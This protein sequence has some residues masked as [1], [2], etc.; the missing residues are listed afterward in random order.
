MTLWHLVG[1]SDWELVC[2]AFENL[3]SCMCLFQSVS[4]PT[5]I[6]CQGSPPATATFSLLTVLQPYCSCSTYTQPP[7]APHGT[8]PLP[9]IAAHDLFCCSCCAASSIRF[10]FSALSADSSST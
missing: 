7:N 9:C 10:F 5:T 2:L 3:G 8:A 6:N 4:M 1:L